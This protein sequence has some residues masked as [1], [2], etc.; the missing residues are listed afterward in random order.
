MAQDESLKGKGMTAAPDELYSALD[1]ASSAYIEGA[2]SNPEINEDH[3]TLLFRNPG[4]P[5]SL[6]EKIC[7]DTRWTKVYKIKAGIVNH[8][9]TPRHLGMNFI[10][11]LFWKD[12]LTVADNFRLYPP[13][14][15]LAEELIKTRLEEMALGEKVSLAQMACRPIIAKLRESNEPKIIEALLKNWRT[16]EEDVVTIARNDGISPEILS[17]IARDRKWGSRYSVRMAV[18]MNE[19][20]PVHDSLRSLKGL[21]KKDLEHLRD[22]KN[23]RAFLQ[24]A[25]SRRLD[26]IP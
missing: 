3:I 23:L 12:L 11:F 10:K 9:H 6:I 1:R 20:T 7:D 26:Q 21:L 24:L 14:R 8:P 17:A 5:S 19:R 13:L 22:N 16:I 18:L 15:R 2:L 25:A 4:L